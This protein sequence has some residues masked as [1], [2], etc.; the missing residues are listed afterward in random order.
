MITIVAT[1]AVA[2]M[3]LTNAVREPSIPANAVVAI[4]GIASALLILC[5]IVEPPVF[6]VEPTITYEGAA[7]LPIFLALLAAAGIA[8]GGLW[9]LREE[10]ASL[11]SYAG[12]RS[13]RRIRL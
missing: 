12:S 5:R 7:Q 2:A 6:Y 13:A 9:A 4:L 10:N 1:L 11:F 3:R 8:F